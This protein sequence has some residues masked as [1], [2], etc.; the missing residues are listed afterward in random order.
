[1]NYRL[2]V[3]P[4]K[5]FKLEFFNAVFVFAEPV[6]ETVADNRRKQAPPPVII[7]T[8]RAERDKE[9]YQKPRFAESLKKIFNFLHVRTSFQ[10][11]S[12]AVTVTVNYHQRPDRYAHDKAR[13]QIPPTLNFVESD[14]QNRHNDKIN[15]APR[16]IKSLAHNTR[17]P[18]NK[19]ITEN[20]ARVDKNF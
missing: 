18:F 16:D 9:Q 12:A 2:D 19:I 10:A 14:N 3:S 13:E 7:K 4:E 5:F 15:Y 8:N 1:M 6:A 17:P 20:I 11:A